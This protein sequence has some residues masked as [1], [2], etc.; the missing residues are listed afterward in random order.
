MSLSDILH[1]RGVSWTWKADGT[2]DAGVVAQEVEAVRPDMVHELEGVKLVNYT[3]LVG[4]LIEAVKELNR[5]NEALSARVT[6]LET[7]EPR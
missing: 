2:R 1:L 7:H 3:G 4:L 6:Q 5:R